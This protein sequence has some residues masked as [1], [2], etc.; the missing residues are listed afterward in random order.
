MTA[1]RLRFVTETK[2][3][4]DA[5][6]LS[7]ARLAGRTAAELEGL[8]LLVGNREL[9]LGELAE[10]TAGDSAVLQ[11]EGAF[12]GLDRL[13][14]GMAEGRIEV[15]GDVGAY[16]GQ[17]M[18]G[19]RIELFG[20]AGVHAAASMRGGT[21]HIT[22]NAGDFLGAALPG[23]A[24]GMAEGVVMVGGATR[25]PH[26]Q[27]AVGE[28]FLRQLLIMTCSTQIP[29]HDLLEIHGMRG[30]SI[31]TIILGMIVPIRLVS[32]Y[33]RVCRARVLMFSAR[34]RKDRFHAWKRS[35]RSRCWR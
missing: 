27:R 21:I 26:V 14:H 10:V 13:G 6:Q 12:A 16:L 32:C 18:S 11:I 1:V 15:Y 29:R 20:S 17:G 28:F 8:R 3:P 31:G 5:R 9:P 24:A 19:G 25:M 33:S 22:A 34:R 30:T 23:D 7:P 2:L 4:V 35:T